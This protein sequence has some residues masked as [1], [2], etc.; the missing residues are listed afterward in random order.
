M[1]DP[2]ARILTRRFRVL[3]YDTRGHGE[4][5]TPPGPY[6]VAMLGRDVLGLLDALAIPRAHF[7][8]L[9]MGGLI[10]QWLGIHAPERMGRLALANTAAKIGDAAD[11]Q[12]R[13][14]TIASRGMAGV[15]AGTP[16]R[17]F[18]AGFIEREPAKVAHWSDHI[19]AADPDGYMANCAMVATTDFRGSLG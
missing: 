13:I 9:S 17:W 11:W 14:D 1:W 7:C 19:G 3:R 12:A 5:A 4:S 18:T 8:G 2:V 6:D 10:G 15:A 16:A